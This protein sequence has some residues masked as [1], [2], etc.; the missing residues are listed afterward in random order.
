VPAFRLRRNA[1]SILA[2]A[3]TRWSLGGNSDAERGAHRPGENATP[4]S[5]KPVWFDLSRQSPPQEA[6]V[7]GWERPRHRPFPICVK[8]PN[9]RRYEGRPQLVKVYRPVRTSSPTRLTVKL[10]PADL[11]ATEETLRELARDL[12][13]D[14][15]AVGEWI[16]EVGRS[17]AMDHHYST[18]V[19]VA[20]RIEFVEIEVQV[21]HH[22]AEA[23]FIVDILFSAEP[24]VE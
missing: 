17:A 20:E 9:G 24:S 1:G 12:Y 15:G 5:R 13:L 21:E 18:R 23:R 16:A 14:E 6:A 2:A 4:D 7:H 19:F 8:L 11:A 10:P 3:L 22:V